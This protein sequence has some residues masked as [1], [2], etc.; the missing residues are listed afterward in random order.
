M[1]DSTNTSTHRLLWSDGC[2][3]LY[4]HVHV[5]THITCVEICICPSL[6]TSWPETQEELMLQFKAR[7]R[8]DQCPGSG[9]RL[10]SNY[11]F[12]RGGSALWFYLGPQLIGRSPPTVGESSVHGFK[13]NL[14]PKH[15]G[16]QPQNNVGANIWALCGPVV[17]PHKISYHIPQSYK[18]Q[19]RHPPL[20]FLCFQARS[21]E[22][23]G[24]SLSSG[25]SF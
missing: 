4:V 7:G 5:H 12:L 21:P 1:T 24:V 23:S 8:Q 6:K 22:P 3:T 18:S 15:P 19:I 20:L 25:T 16:R 14:T 13:C 17:L 10:G 9:V 11:F 2:Y